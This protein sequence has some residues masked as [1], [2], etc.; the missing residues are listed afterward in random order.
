MPENSLVKL[1]STT[2][3]IVEGKMRKITQI[4]DSKL[5]NRKFQGTNIPLSST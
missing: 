1:W 5:K 4:I 2:G 3:G